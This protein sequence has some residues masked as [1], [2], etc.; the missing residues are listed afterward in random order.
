MF[1]IYYERVYTSY[2]FMIYHPVTYC[3]ILLRSVLRTTSYLKMWWNCTNRI[4]YMIP[5]SYWHIIRVW[6][7]IWYV[8]FDKTEKYKI[9]LYIY[10]IWYFLKFHM[11]MYNLFSHVVVSIYMA[12]YY[13][14]KHHF[15]VPFSFLCNAY[16]SY[17]IYK[18]K[19]SST[20]KNI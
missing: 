2:I 18:L 16:N 7:M 11:C 3:S 5:L 1:Y 6:D 8:F 17:N 12:R 10:N 4:W 13:T 15:S 19:K 20:L 9:M 14:S